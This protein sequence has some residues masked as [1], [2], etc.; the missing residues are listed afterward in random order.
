LCRILLLLFLLNSLTVM[1]TYHTYE[2]FL[3]PFRPL[4]HTMCAWGLSASVR[5]VRPSLFRSM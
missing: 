4:I 5:T 1:A 3:T 2:R